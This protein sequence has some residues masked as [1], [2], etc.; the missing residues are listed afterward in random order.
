MKPGSIDDGTSASYRL[1]A[2]LPD[3]LLEAE[4]FLLALAEVFLPQ[5][6]GPTGARGG[7]AAWR[8]REREPPGVEDRYRILV[9][10]IP[11]VVFMAY[12]DRGIGEAYVSP[13]IEAIL[14]FTQEEWLNDPV[15]WYRQIHPDDKGRWSV[16]AA[17][18]VLTGRP[19]RSVY[20]VLARD[21]RVVWFHCEAKMV[22]ADDGRPWFIHGVGFDVSEL[23]R[24]EEALRESEAMLRELF[25]SAPDTVVVVDGDGRIARANAQIEQMFGFGQEELVGKPVEVLLSERFRR[26]HVRHREGY[27]AEP[28]TRPMGAGLELFCRRKDG[29]EIPVDIMLSPVERAEGGL[30]IAVVRD[31]TNRKRAEE[32]LK[33]REEELRALSASLLSVQDE[34]RRRIARELHDST[35][36]NLAGLAMNLSLLMTAAATVS[37][38]SLQRILSDSRALAE[39]CSREV[40]NLSYLLHPPLLDDLGLAPALK[41]YIAG[42]GQRT[43]IEV[44]LDVPPDLGRLA[45]EIETAL[46]RIVQEG[47]TNVHR[48][49]GST[50]AAIRLAL[51]DREVKLTVEDEGAGSTARA[52]EDGVRLGVGIPGMRERAKQLGGHMDIDA[53]HDG[54]IITVSLPRRS[55][56]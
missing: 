43:G 33:R 53:G 49:S 13:Q 37:D 47:L 36:Q 50:R 11:A 21:G 35:A 2:V 12:L 7:A 42:F 23:K 46:F 10:Q 54:T 55:G 3:G 45:P 24:A 20:R 51:T 31:I 52:I 34:E 44:Q 41:S 15:R 29:T 48:H 6:T 32:A 39:Q 38:P 19:L 27:L 18:M 30:V 16:E 17:Q 4:S 9:E 40:R 14:G 28:R 56:N 25:D 26:S 8:A 5:A 22:R 1:G